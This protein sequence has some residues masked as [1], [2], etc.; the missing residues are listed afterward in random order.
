MNFFDE[1]L[2]L[3]KH[4]LWNEP[5]MKQET[6]ER[7][8]WA[9]DLKPSCRNWRCDERRGSKRGSH[10]GRR[11]VLGQEGRLSLVWLTFWSR[12]KDTALFCPFGM[13][14]L[15]FAIAQLY[16]DWCFCVAVF[17]GIIAMHTL[18][19]S[20]LIL[21]STLETLRMLTCSLLAV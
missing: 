13:F 11:W 14:W 15:S 7:E 5:A 20:G 18:T 10:N 17:I 3:Q 21:F 1:M 16:Y 4:R 8:K 19:H 12:S 9:S 2:Q 6:R